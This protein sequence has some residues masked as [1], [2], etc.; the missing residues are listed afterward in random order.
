[1]FIHYSY[2][3]FRS[4]T[5]EECE[6]KYQRVLICSLKGYALYLSKIPSDH[7]K[8]ALNKNIALLDN[9]KFWSYQKHK[10]ASIRGSWFEALAAL[11][12]YAPDLIEKYDK[13]AASAALQ[14][15]DE[16]ETVVL[17]HVWASNLLVTQKISNWYVQEN[18][19]IR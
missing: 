8:E 10:N 7:L 19:T 9:S 16:T 14:N 18:A 2:L 4:N 11:L 3:S 13:Q 6:A 5:L 17:P 1:M 12:Q 15:L